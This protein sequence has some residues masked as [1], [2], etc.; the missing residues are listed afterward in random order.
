MVDFYAVLGVRP[1]ADEASV[2]AAYRRLARQLH[3]DVNRAPDAAVQMRELNAAYKT[4]SDFSQRVAYDAS[5]GHTSATGGSAGQPESRP[6]SAVRS[7]GPRPSPTGTASRPRWHSTTVFH[8]W[9]APAMTWSPRRRPATAPASPR[10]VSSGTSTAGTADPR[11]VRAGALVGCT[12]LFAAFAGWAMVAIASTPAPRRSPAASWE[13]S[14][15][16]SNGPISRSAPGELAGVQVAAVSNTAARS[17]ASAN[18]L[19][20]SSGS[21]AG[22]TVALN[23]APAPVPSIVPAVPPA[24]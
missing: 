4:L 7:A 19:R 9:H 3:P 5:R 11:L 8:T 12:V 15:G 20:V 2:R 1:G 22:G 13:T 24:A 10:P 18:A 6:A 14:G 23:G 16:S 21:P 17:T